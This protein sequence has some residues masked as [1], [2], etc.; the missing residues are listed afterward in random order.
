MNARRNLTLFAG[1]VCAIFAGLLLLLAAF[2]AVTGASVRDPI[3]FAVISVFPMLIA[4]ACLS[5]KH[6]TPAL[7]L[8]GGITAFAIAGILIDSFVNPKVEVP[9]KGRTIYFVMM[10]GAATIAAKGRW[11]S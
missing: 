7:R 9:W 4:I 10:A 6:R 8:V 11:P 5:A 1:I 2:L 3:V